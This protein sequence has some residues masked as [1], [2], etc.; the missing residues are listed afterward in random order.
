MAAHPFGDHIR[1]KR[2][3][4]LAGDQRFSLRR[5]AARLGIQASY[6]SR[7]ER[8]AAPSLSE[9]HI[10]A[11]AGELGEDPDAL[12]ALAGKIPSDV[13]QA[14]LAR[15]AVFAAL[16]RDLAGR[17][18]AAL[19][20]CLGRDE[21]WTSF[22]ETQRLARVG[23]FSRDLATGRDV[24]SDEFFRIFG[25]PEDSPTPTFEQFHALV[26]PEDR[27]AVMAVRQKLLSGTVPVRYTYRFRRADGVWRHARAVARSACDASGHVTRVF[28][29]VQDVTTERQA[30][31]DLRCVARFPEDNPNPVLRVTGEGLLAYANRAAG[32]VLDALGLAV[33]QAV[34]R[35]LADILAEALGAGQARELDL[36]IGDRVLAFTVVPLPASG[37]ANLYGRDV[38]GERLAREALAEAHNRLATLAGADIDRRMLRVLLDVSMDPVVF[39]SGDGRFLRVNDVFAR[40]LGQ[41]Y[42]GDPDRMAGLHLTDVFDA[43]TAGRIAAR[44]AAAMADGGICQEEYAQAVTTSDGV[45]RLLRVRRGPLRDASGAVVGVC[46]VGR[47]VT[48]WR[49]TAHALAETEA[50]Y[51]RLFDDAMLGV[52]RATASGRVLSV[53]PTMARLFG[54]DSPG[55]MVR[56]LGDTSGGAYQ[57]PRRREEIV[58]RLAEEGGL[59]RFE[60][61]YRRKDGSVFIGNLHARL[62]GGGDEEPVVEGFVED[63]TARKRMEMELAASEER[64]KTHLRNFPL[65]T[66]TFC[67]RDRELV[68]VDANKAAEVL[69]RGRIGACLEAP[70]GAI[71][72]EAPEVY[73]ALWGAL[74]SRRSDRRRLSFRPPGVAEPGI[75]DMTFVF[76]APDTVMLHAE[77]ITALARTR[78]ALRRTS[79]QLRGILDHV[80]CAV[81]F[82][83]PAGRCIMV[84]RGVEDIFGLPA[85]DIVGQTP[86]YVHDPEVAARIAEDDRR[87]MASG[88][89]V[90]FEEEIIARGRPRRF[91]TT[92]VP[93]RDENGEPYAICGMSLDITPQKELERDIKAERD[94]LRT[95]LA[96]VPYAATL[97]SAE[98]RTLYINQRFIDLVGYTLDDIPDI[99]SW[100][101]KAYPDPDLRR[102]VRADWQ[103]CLGTDSRRAY[104]VR[105]GD[106]KTRLLDFMSVNLPDGRMLLTLTEIESDPPQGGGVSAPGRRA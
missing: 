38:T 52:F 42:G 90:T 41:A 94:T 1:R 9:N 2:L 69:F 55:E 71:F 18:D 29:T 33:G 101:P 20:N 34:D 73:L 77:E 106:G 89:A 37:Y 36:A 87:V 79:A 21:L 25:L 96:N 14:L 91:L 50:R 43:D 45:R 82:K 103:A 98:G 31:E 62:A 19:T 51:R 8:G 92:K 93:L 7:L 75:F 5:L 24:W 60:N 40:A 27:D 11:L 39:V 83:D 28:G 86:G 85:E 10:V 67:L 15:P 22:Q 80:P 16:V 74:E 58:R 104:P 63:I 46:A 76:A 99:K 105:C 78:E 65:P 61:T 35:P 102:R 97:V 48:E 23:S 57:D 30:L 59:Q 68:L 54:Y 4:L 44:D 12:L 13:R 70:A 100:W 56:M 3:A 53:N 47:D 49:Q 26:H 32:P 95:V 72:D 84:N 17:S 81:Y 88:Q 66:L 6:L 64:L